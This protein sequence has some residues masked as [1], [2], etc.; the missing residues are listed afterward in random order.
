MGLNIIPQFRKDGKTTTLD[1]FLYKLIKAK[2][3]KSENVKNLKYA[4]TKC[5]A[6]RGYLKGKYWK[7][8]IYKYKAY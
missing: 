5:L 7:Q 2:S 3:C 6:L 1:S 4:I 8:I